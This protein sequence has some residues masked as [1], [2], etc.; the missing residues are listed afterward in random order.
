MDK[1][2]LVINGHPDPRPERFGSALSRAFGDGARNAGW[3]VHTLEATTLRFTSGTTQAE[4][5]QDMAAG[6]VHAA[7]RLAIVFPLW[8]DEPPAA[9]GKLLAHAAR[10]RRFAQNSASARHRTAQLVV[11]MEMPAFIHRSMVRAD[12]RRGDGHELESLP[13]LDSAN[14]TFIGS[15]GAITLEQRQEWLREIRQ[16]GGQFDR[17]VKLP[18]RWLPLAARAAA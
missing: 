12:G 11:T 3:S 7:D 9:V 6:L 17:V 2:L 18:R 1:H 15:V 13:G 8:F 14:V 4:I 5:S 16:L 10:L